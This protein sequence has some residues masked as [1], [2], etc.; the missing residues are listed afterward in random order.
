VSSVRPSTCEQLSQRDNSSPT[1]NLN[2]AASEPDNFARVFP[3]LAAITTV[4][5]LLTLGL[6]QTAKPSSK[7]LPPNAFKIKSVQVLGTSRYKPAE[8][9]RA[10]NL[11]L[12]QSFHDDDLRSMVRVLGESGAFASVSYSLQFE[13]DGAE[14]KIKLRDADRFF[15]AHFDNVVWFTDRELFEKLHARVPLFDGQLPGNGA[16]ANEV[17]DALQLLLTEKNVAGQV[18]C[19]RPFDE[20]NPVEAFVFTVSGPNIT[21]RNVEFSGAGPAE[22]PT[23]TSDAKELVG[24]E[25]RRPAIRAME[26]NIFLSIYREHGYLKAVFG[27]PRPT[28]V[29]NDAHDTLV[30]VLV[31]VNPAQQYRLA[32]IQI[33][34]NKDVPDAMLRAAFHVQ[35]GEVANVIELEKNLATIHQ[36]CGTR[37]YMD[38]SA[39]AEVRT[40]DPKLTV[41]YVVSIVEGEIYKMGEVEIRGLDSQTTARFKNEWTLRRGDTYDASYAGRFVEQAYKEIGEPWHA[42]VHEFADPRTKTVDVTVRF[43]P[44]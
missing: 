14:L 1:S 27:D 39:K 44:S 2:A 9:M 16:M 3:R 10:V 4:C 13:A 35:D 11:R 15:R 31:P 42:S 26:E 33:S 38:A 29:Q 18:N 25:Y 22:L 23:L 34:G 5:C 24:T 20:D 8:V 43:D 30:D 32:G 37:G 6:A 28:V 40:Q 17:S 19:L 7:D 36:I 12:G 41:V 21:I